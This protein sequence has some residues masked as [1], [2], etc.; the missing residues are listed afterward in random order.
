[1]FLAQPCLTINKYTISSIKMTRVLLHIFFLGVMHV[2]PTVFLV[3]AKWRTV[4]R[5][6][7]WTLCSGVGIYAVLVHF[8]GV[9]AHFISA[10]LGQ[11][12]ENRRRGY[13]KQGQV[14][15]MPHLYSILMVN[16]DIPVSV[17]T[18]HVERVPYYTLFSGST[19]DAGI[20]S[21]IGEYI[22]SFGNVITSFIP[23]Y[24]KLANSAVV[25]TERRLFHHWW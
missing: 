14:D 4:W 23:K 21:K 9:V 17:D 2:L 8:M 7:H 3:K 12:Q 18:T 5:V 22:H 16:R 24:D 6:L 19:T 13:T 15:C 1:M 25:G 10:L 20:S 11:S